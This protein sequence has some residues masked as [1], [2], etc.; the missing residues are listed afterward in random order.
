M[1]RCANSRPRSRQ[2]LGA[3]PANP[4]A[5]RLWS[6]RRARSRR[7]W[8]ARRAPAEVDRLARGARRPACSPPIRC[9][10]RP[11]PRPIS[12]RGAQL[13]AE[14]LRLLPRRDRAAPTRRWRASSI[15][16]RSPSPT[17]TRARERSLFAPLPGDR[18]GARRHGDA[19][20]RPAARRGPLGAR[21]PCRP[22]RLS[23]GARR[24]RAPRSGEADPALRARI[25]NL[26]ALVAI[27]PAALARE[28]GAEKAAAVIAY[29]RA[30]PERADASAAARNR[31]PSRTNC[32]RQSLAAYRRGD[33]DAGRRAGA[34]RL[35]RRLRAGRGAA[36]RP[37]RR[38]G[39][40]GRSARWAGCAPRSRAAR[41]RPTSRRRVERLQA[42]FGRAEAAL[43]PE[44]GSGAS[45]F[46]GALRH[47]AARGAGGAADRGRDDRLPAQGRAPRHA[48]LCPCRLDRRAGRRRRDLVGGEPSHHHQRRRAAS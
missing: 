40:R 17:A 22:L 4:R 44:A 6:P 14:Q 23:R 27:T 26:E 5:A 42:L 41:R 19:E 7:R 24:A 16:R 12:P 34:G 1:T 18:P 9:R 46:L 39:R 32:S 8:R 13:Y 33:R 47:P 11:P 29:L 30:N 28:I 21:L 31:W 3:L 10:S 37:R 20:L 43:A 35:S 25:P 2:R 38:P 36:R 45:T 48:A 15:R